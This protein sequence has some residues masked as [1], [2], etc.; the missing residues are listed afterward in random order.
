MM[1]FIRP[2][3]PPH[4]LAATAL[5]AIFTIAAPFASAQSE[6]QPPPAKATFEVASVRPSPPNH[7]YT[8]ISPFGT[9]HFTATNA[10]LA[11][12]IQ[13]A[14][15]IDAPNLL[16]GK[17]D[18]LDS[19]YFDINAKADDDAKLNYE[20]VKPLLQLLLQQ[21]FHLQTH[22]ESKTVPGYALVVAKDGPK[23]HPSNSAKPY[24]Y[25]L[26]GKFRLQNA[27]MGSFAGVLANPIGQPVVDKTGIP[28]NY[29]FKIDY[30][31]ENDPNS[32]LPT[33]FTALEEQ[34][35]LKLEPQKVPIT[36]VTIDH[37]DKTPTE[38]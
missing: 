11:Y 23:L 12:L 20:Q 24:A 18:W 33:L 26:S 29:D 16:A 13:L 4:I 35:G 25:I 37:I 14:Y 15:E 31:P 22:N 28:G 38:N 6:T 3:S 5:L 1:R 2:T 32:T 27:S 34:L 17:P 19:A 7:G 10:S 21:R 9:S 36:I 30:A 8:S